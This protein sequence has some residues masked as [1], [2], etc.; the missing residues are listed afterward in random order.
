M[1]KIFLVLRFF[2]FYS[3]A[4]C[5]SPLN[6]PHWELQWDDEFITGQT[7]NPA[8]GTTNLVSQLW[9]GYPMV[10]NWNIA[11][12]NDHGG[13]VQVY[14]AGPTN[15]PN[16]NVALVPGTGLVL[17]AKQEDHQCFLCAPTCSPCVECCQPCS[18]CQASC[19]NN[20]P[21]VNHHYTSGSISLWADPDHNHILPQYGYM[22]A[23][24]KLS[25]NYGLFPAFWT[26]RQIGN[27]Y[28][29]I[30]IFEMTPGRLELD[31]NL[32]FYNVVSNKNIMTN[33]LH[34]ELNVI[35][36][37][38]RGQSL[39]INDYTTPHTY[40]LEWSPSKLIYYVDDKVI[41]NSE[42]IGY[43][44]H[45][46]N[47]GDISF[48]TSII[49]NL[50]IDGA[51]GYDDN[52]N[53]PNP[54][55]YDNYVPTY[56]YFDP[57]GSYATNYNPISINTSNPTTGNSRMAIEYVK[58]YKLKNLECNNGIMLP[59]TSD[60][61]LNSYTSIEKYSIEINPSSQVSVSAASPKSL[62]A[63][64]YILINGE[65][66]TNGFEFYLD[67]NPCY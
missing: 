30:D 10:G 8:D 14:L 31:Q 28:N 36:G 65:F 53:N 26:T 46:G 33:N 22:E 21:F 29:E 34:T 24:I 37:P 17:T 40:G 49:L 55:W 67:V 42:N 3:F 44:A 43:S 60:N 1:K 25:D 12:D 11:N 2:C 6:D 5:Q 38:N 57:P 48:P 54:D 35:N 16:S 56:A 50:A 45:P 58:Y 47:G 18:L 7:W 59:I 51:V 32:L 13:D 4:F 66:N 9:Q 19:Y 39:Y 63:A 15:N 61:D 62:R 41:R 27:L 23:R 20:C 52:P 64:Q